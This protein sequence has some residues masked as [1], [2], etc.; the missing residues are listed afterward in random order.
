MDEGDRLRA[1]VVIEG[2]VQ[3]VWFRAWTRE[4]AVAHG[5]SGWVRNRRDGAVEAVFD[6]P[7]AI[8]EMMIRA[9]W[10]GPSAARVLAVRVDPI[11]V[12]EP[13]EGFTVLPSA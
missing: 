3:G 2:K 1:H 12:E 11:P 4:R 8:V 13:I 7:T 9:C 5:L 10:D 6:G